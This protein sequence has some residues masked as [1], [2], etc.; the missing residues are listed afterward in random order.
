VYSQYWLPLACL[1][2]FEFFFLL[3]QSGKVAQLHN[4]VPRFGH[5]RTIAKVATPDSAD[6]YKDGVRS[7]LVV[8]CL[9]VL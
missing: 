9:F 4:G 2:I 5:S 6:D 7:M 8:A 3:L 1:T